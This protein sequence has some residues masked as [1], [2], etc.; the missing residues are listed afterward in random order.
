MIGESGETT[1]LSPG[2][3]PK[4]PLPEIGLYDPL[5]V[6]KLAPNSTHVTRG[7]VKNSPGGA[8]FVPSP[9]KTGTNL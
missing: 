2:R 8:V 6:G 1:I 4:Q 3:S 9:F 5:D 7:S